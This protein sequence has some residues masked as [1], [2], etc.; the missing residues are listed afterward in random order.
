[1]AVAYTWSVLNMDAY[2]QQD[3]F[4]NVVCTIHWV[5]NGIDNGLTGTSPGATG[6][7]LDPAQ[8]FTPYNQ[9][10][11]DQVLSWVFASLGEQGVANVE[12]DVAAQIA[13]KANQP[14][15]QPLPWG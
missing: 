15:A 8:P 7:A 3:G 10:T 14:V 9:L 6:V 11:Q 13:Y 4:Q 5:C 1:M 2:P 12:S